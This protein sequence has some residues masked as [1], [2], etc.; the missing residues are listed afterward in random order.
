[1]SLNMSTFDAALKQHYTHDRIEN[2]VYKDN[3]FFAMVSKMKNFD[4]RNLPVPIK[5]GLPQGISS[6]FSTAQSNITNTYL[7]A[8]LLTRAKHYSVASIDN[9]TIEAS[10]NDS[11]AFLSALTLEIDGAIE[12][13]A[14]ELAVAL[15]RDGSGAIGQASVAV[16]SG[17]T[18]TLSL[19]D[20]IANFE[21]GMVLV[22][23]ATTTGTLKSGSLSVV[24]VNRDAGTMVLSA[25][26]TTI[27]GGTGIAASDY[28][29]RQ[30]NQSLSVTGIQGWLPNTAPTS[31][32]SFF[33]IDRSAD[34]VRLAGI[35]Y[36][37][38]GMPIEEALV[39]AAAKV[40]Q[41]GGRPDYCFLSYTQYAALEKA[42]GSK[43]QYVDKN[44][45]PEIGFRGI[46]I[47]GP[48]GPISVIPDQN[49]PG[50]RAFM[51]SME[52]W[53]LYSLGD[54]PKII[55]TD[56]LKFLRDSS[57]DSVQVRVGAYAQLGCRA[58]G[59]NANIQLL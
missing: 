22:F 12:G 11:G 28:I 42:L 34:S 35:R 23:C 2:M 50:N 48:R 59:F 47:H 45:T 17:T 25:A 21:V 18:L 7:K 38:R 6:T 20:D 39:D 54:A 14:R 27:D 53:K 40:G 26:G 33:G 36:D 43:V 44:I 51:L 55:Q 41:L 56:G 46:M 4:G 52:Y 13:V 29:F 15:F 30:G 31:G 5:Y 16:T 3:P 32:D 19:A 49:C 58:P 24:S 57:A 10:K 37:G 9:E 1:M 8:F